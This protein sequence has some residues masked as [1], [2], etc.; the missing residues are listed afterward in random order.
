MEL[1]T[2]N[3]LA[4]K[5]G[6]EEKDDSVESMIEGHASPGILED[7]VAK[8]RGVR[9]SYSLLDSNPACDFKNSWNCGDVWASLGTHIEAMKYSSCDNAVDLCAEVVRDEHICIYEI[10]KSTQ[11]WYLFRKMRGD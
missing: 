2:K 1:D 9:R 4:E 3:R 7:A 5:I 11:H 6:A 8:P 10:I